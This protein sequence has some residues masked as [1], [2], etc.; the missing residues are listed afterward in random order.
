MSI[1]DGDTSRKIDRADGL[2]EHHAMSRV[3]VS[4]RVSFRMD[5]TDVVDDGRDRCDNVVVEGGRWSTRDVFPSGEKRN[6]IV[7]S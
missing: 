6:V 5:D 3:G 2:G 1:D 7:S 4:F